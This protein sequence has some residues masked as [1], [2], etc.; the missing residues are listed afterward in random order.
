LSRTA[1]SCAGCA[2]AREGQQQPRELAVVHA[3]LEQSQLIG[4]G[5]QHL[6]NVNGKRGFSLQ[7]RR[8]V[9]GLLGDEGRDL[10]FGAFQVTLRI[11]L[12]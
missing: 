1:S 10:R 7:S 9:A 4:I 6:Q 12:S 11:A 2:A 5:S 3:F 8:R